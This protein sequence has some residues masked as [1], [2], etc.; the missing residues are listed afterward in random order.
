MDGLMMDFPLTLDV[1]LRRAETTHGQ[2]EVVTRLP[3]RSWHRY[4]YADMARRAKSLAVGLAGLGVRPGDRVGT[5][6]WNHYRHLE[7]YF[8]IPAGG[9]VLHTLNLRLHPDELAFIVN[10]AEDRI[11][12]VDESLLP[13]W[14]AISDKVSVEHLIVVAEGETVPDGAISYETLLSGS[15]WEDFHQPRLTEGQAASMCY[16]SGTA[17][18]VE[19]S[20]ILSP[21]DLLAYAVRR[22]DLRLRDPR[23]GLCAACRSHV[24]CQRMGIAVHCRHDW[25]E[26]GSARAF[27]GP[28]ELGRMH[29][30]RKGD[31][32][33]GRSDRLVFAVE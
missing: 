17:G 31:V 3:D 23:D 25:S 22:S 10:Q 15:N 7:A 24:P 2:R 27:L 28:Q 12:V 32:H 26:N 8:G 29:G 16:T 9:A 21:S 20:C 13:I 30:S 33:G 11:V 1:I 19:R 5:L 18:Q 6:C 4:S 14:D